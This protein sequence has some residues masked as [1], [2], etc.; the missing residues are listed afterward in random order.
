MSSLSDKDYESFIL[1]LING[2]QSLGYHEAF[3]ALVN[4][5]LRRKDKVPFKSTSAEELTVRGRSF[6][7][8]GKDNCGRLKSRP[9]FKI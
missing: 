5:E 1:T 4:H 9:D 2:K 8:K 3:Y 7:Q 6:S